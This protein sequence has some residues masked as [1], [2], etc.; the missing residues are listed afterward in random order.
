MMD[1][2]KAQ[3]NGWVELGR[4]IHPSTRLLSPARRR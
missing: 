3:A 2:K 1:N 4:L